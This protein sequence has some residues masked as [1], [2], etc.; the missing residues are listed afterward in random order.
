MVR[1]AGILLPVSFVLVVLGVGAVFY[2]I[3]DTP[4]VIPAN[5]TPVYGYRVVAD[6]PH[7][8]NAFTEGFVFFDGY[9][10]EGTGLNGKSS[11]RQQ[12]LTSGEMLQSVALPQ[13]Y[14]GEGITILGDKVYQLTWQSR[15]GFVYDLDFEQVQEFGYSTEGWG[16]THNGSHLIMSD[17]TS[18]LYFID[19]ANF[20]VV[21]QVQVKDGGN[22]V[23]K[24]NELEYINGEVWAN[25]W[26]TDLVAR[27]SPH[28]GEV[29]GWVDFTGILTSAERVGTD[30][31]NGIAFDPDSDRILVTG[32]YWPKI[33]QVELVP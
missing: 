23:P 30:V 19:P 13:Q 5:G 2:F 24:L 1:N 22:I 8:K 33:F 29:L 28:S 15:K 9:L 4:P 18:S 10:Y 14:F 31:L 20:S 11:V 25:V 27:I 26:Q 3:Q 17:G 12:N 32:K 21:G 16:L 6:F 7:D